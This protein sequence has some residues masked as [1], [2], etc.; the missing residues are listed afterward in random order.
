MILQLDF[1]HGFDKLIIKFIVLLQNGACDPAH[2]ERHEYTGYHV[3]F[4]PAINW[5]EGFL[6]SQI[7]VHAKARVENDAH[8]LEV[9]EDVYV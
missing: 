9:L 5:V 2:D 8:V 6:V 4:Y 3:Y 1:K 7:E